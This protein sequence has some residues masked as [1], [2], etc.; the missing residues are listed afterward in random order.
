MQP[1]AGLFILQDSFLSAMCKFIASSLSQWKF[2]SSQTYS[3]LTDQK[4][5]LVDTA[6]EKENV[7]DSIHLIENIEQEIPSTDTYVEHCR[8]KRHRVNAKCNEKENLKFRRKFRKGYS[9]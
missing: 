7:I 3:E 4:S 2:L 8:R 5:K 9:S 1:I 6:A